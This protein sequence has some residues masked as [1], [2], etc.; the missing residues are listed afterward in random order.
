MSIITSLGLVESIIFLI[1]SI[2]HLY[3]A[4]NGKWGFEES[5]PQNENG[6]QVLNPKKTDSTIVGIGLFIFASF[7]WI[8]IEL[9]VIELP[10][11]LM[12]YG[13]WVISTIFIF[14][15][16]GDFKYIGI[17]KKIRNTN[18]GKLDTRF[19]SPLCLVIG[20]IGIIIEL[21]I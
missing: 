1:L 17:F 16:I 20:C 2:L 21:S 14:R 7:Y 19:Y 5:V 3:W 15:A 18:F 6:E 8:K 9:I 12:Q 10:F 4:L 11:Y 13:G